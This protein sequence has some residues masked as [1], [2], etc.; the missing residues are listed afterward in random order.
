MPFSNERIQ[1]KQGIYAF[2][3]NSNYLKKKETLWPLSM[4]GVQLPQG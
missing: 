4:D 1:R 3:A 2:Y